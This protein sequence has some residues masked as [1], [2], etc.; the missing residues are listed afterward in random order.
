MEYAA[1]VVVLDAVPTT[2]DV[3]VFAGVHRALAHYDR[4]DYKQGILELAEWWEGPG[5]RPIL[6]GL[7]P[8]ARAELLLAAG[9]LTSADGH[10]RR[11]RFSQR[12]ARTL[13]Q[14]SMEI[15]DPTIPA[16][17]RLETE[18]HIAY[19]YFYEGNPAEA[20]KRFEALLPKSTGGLRLWVVLRL[21]LAY[22]RL[23][24][25]VEAKL[26]L[27]GQRERLSEM[28]SANL[29]GHYHS[30]WGLVETYNAQTEAE[31]DAALMQYTQAA[32]EYEQ[33]GNLR[34]LAVVENNIGYLKSR[35]GL[36]ED[37]LDHTFK[38]LFIF[39]SI[40]DDIR[41]AS[42]LDTLAR[43]HCAAGNYEEAMWANSEGLQLLA[44]T[45]AADLVGEAKETRSYIQK[46]RDGEAPVLDLPLDPSHLVYSLISESSANM[47]AESFNVLV[48]NDGMLYAGIFPD[49]ERTFVKREPKDGMIVAAEIDGEVYVAYYHPSPDGQYVTLSFANPE[50]PDITRPAD[51]VQV[52]GVLTLS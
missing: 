42:C 19:S 11:V 48:T 33:G 26:L 22:W 5:E 52:L 34:F 6:T 14:E 31:I 2:A 37:A 28:A 36:T 38:A 46:Q 15:V 35:L 25:F 39:S 45:D 21:A 7:S 27:E 41:R 12:Y 50:W 13:L 29:R 4:S 8:I 24:Q 44:D 23:G 49:R 32:I 51:R 18:S 1:S 47:K 10:T 3:S 16:R 40:G 9:L 17:V 30:A 43:I 20:K